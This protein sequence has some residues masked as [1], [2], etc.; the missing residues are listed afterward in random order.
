MSSAQAPSSSA[1]RPR[2]HRP[3]CAQCGSRRFRKNP[4][5]GQAICEEGH[6]LQGYREE[7]VQEDGEFNPVSGSQARY[8]KKG[9]RRKKERAAKEI[10]TGGRA[11]FLGYECL[12]VILRLQLKALR[13]EWSHL[14]PEIEA[15][16]RDLWAMYVSMVPALEPT[17]YKEN[18]DFVVG[19][20]RTAR[21]ESR[22]RSSRSRS[23][24]RAARDRSSSGLPDEAELEAEQRLEREIRKVTGEEDPDAEEQA[25]RRREQDSDD[26]VGQDDSATP[27]KPRRRSINLKLITTE[28]M[29]ALVSIIYL[30]L[31]SARVPVLWADLR[32]LLV[33]GRIPYISAS[34]ILPP[35]MTAKLP[36]SELRK[37]EVETV[38]TLAELQARTTRLAGDLTNHFGSTVRFPEL[39]AAPLV[40]R[41]VQEMGLPPTFYQPALELL[42]YLGIPLSVV[43]SHSVADPWSLLG[44]DS[45]KEEVGAQGQPLPPLP[46]RLN[47]SSTPP[48]TTR[49][50]IIMAAI[51]MVLQM[52]YGLDGQPRSND[53]KM[54]QDV[55][56]LP[57]LS[58]YLTALAMS[59][60]S[61]AQSPA[62][63]HELSLRP[64]QLSDDQLDAYLD[65]AEENLLE[66]DQ[67]NLRAGKRKDGFVE[68]IFGGEKR[69]PAPKIARCVKPFDVDEEERAEQQSDKSSLLD[70]Q[71]EMREEMLRHLYGIDKAQQDVSST[72]D[73][74]LRPGEAY[75]IPSLDEFESE[76]EVHPSMQ[77]ILHH[78]AIVVGLVDEEHHQT[79]DW[80][81]MKDLVAEMGHLLL[82]R[83]RREAKLGGGKK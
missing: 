32:N 77:R 58:S 44:M 59:A 45:V 19:Q 57:A 27:R 41:C 71:G 22:A 82:R 50:T 35:A 53:E 34:K 36:E 15:I 3:R 67:P 30:T 31:V 11:S 66:L 9:G 51:V 14:P 55:E 80:R 69:L 79:G 26:E 4:A 23:R 76:E 5:T 75:F 73:P 18:L 1:Q 10:Y 12:Q 28:P 17:P 64:S 13:M 54:S 16:A 52:T 46:T 7:E 68:D 6:I 25:T 38:P 83:I 21:E 20:L 33:S 63:V 72:S 61:R 48:V 24:S 37:I 47:V 70:V 81:G 39:N 40:W 43:P 42:T 49:C 74:S 56:T 2:R 60:L 78:A 8:I 29:Q 62:F 65:F